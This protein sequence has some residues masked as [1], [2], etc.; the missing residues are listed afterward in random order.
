M[1]IETALV[2][3]LQSIKSINR[4]TTITTIAVGEQNTITDRDAA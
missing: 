3:G 4:A 2:L 1:S